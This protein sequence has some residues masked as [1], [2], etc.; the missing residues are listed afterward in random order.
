MQ[1]IDGFWYLD[2]FMESIAAFRSEFQPRTDD[3]VL[4]TSV[5]KTGT[6]WLI[7]LCHSILH[8]DDKEEEEDSLTKMTPH[9][10]VPT[11]DMFYLGD[12]Q[13]LRERNGAR[14]HDGESSGGVLRW[15]HP[16]RAILQTRGGVLGRE[17][18][19]AREGVVS[20]VRGAVQRAQ[21]AGQEAGFV[22]QEAFRF[23]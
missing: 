12:Q 11:I 5:P 9:E 13:N 10:L 7:A 6:T 14:C 1:Q 16:V 23:G 15:G 21:G 18:E 3:V 22:S 4:L 20:R 17:Q 8:R 2:S 19:A